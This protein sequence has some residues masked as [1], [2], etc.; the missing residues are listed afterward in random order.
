MLFRPFRSNFCAPQG[1]TDG[2]VFR[3]VN[4]AD[5]VTGDELGKKTVW[6]LIKPYPNQPASPALPRTISVVRVPNCAAPAAPN[7][8]RGMGPM[9]T[10]NGGFLSL[11]RVR[12]EG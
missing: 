9:N 6:Q 1:V 2:C 3:P 4:R 7:V 8:S 5:R 11:Y 10:L 12:P